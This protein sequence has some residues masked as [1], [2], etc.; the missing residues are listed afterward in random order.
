MLKPPRPIRDILAELGFRHPDA[1]TA[2][3]AALE[4][5]KLTHPGKQNIAAEKLSA[6]VDLLQS[7]F[8]VLCNNP[9]CLQLASSLLHEGRSAL[10]I[11]QTGDCGMCHG[12]ANQRSASLVRERLARRNFRRIVVVGGSPGTRED[13]AEQLKGAAELRFVDSNRRRNNQDAENDLAWADV[14]VIWGN[15]E[16]DHSTSKLYT[17]DRTHK[18]VLQ[19]GKRGVASLLDEI[20]RFLG[21]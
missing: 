19:T 3:R 18:H 11:E 15:T 7:R 6:V 21:N 1:Y 8:V 10:P 20:A 4:E 2:A 12:S 9:R 14:V 16:L 5:A 17:K 13:L